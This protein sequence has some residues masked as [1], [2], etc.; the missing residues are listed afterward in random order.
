M[1]GGLGQ[2]GLVGGSTLIPRLLNSRGE[3]AKLRP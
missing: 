3:T 2:V 1:V